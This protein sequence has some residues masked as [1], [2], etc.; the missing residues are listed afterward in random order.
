MTGVFPF[1]FS[2]SL[3]SHGCEYSSFASDITLAEHRLLFWA[4]Y[5]SQKHRFFT[6]AFPQHRNRMAL[7]SL[8]WETETT[9]Q[10]TRLQVKNNNDE[11]S[12]F[13]RTWQSCLYFW[14]CSA[15]HYQIQTNSRWSLK[16]IPFLTEAE[17]G[18]CTVFSSISCS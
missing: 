15:R 8:F 13:L 17:D 9:K 18:W 5:Y 7:L 11:I 2:A 16:D 12:C 6:P 3:N 14:N 10:G 1:T 4:K